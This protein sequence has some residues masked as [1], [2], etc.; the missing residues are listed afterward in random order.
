MAK[1]IMISGQEIFELARKLA[2]NPEVVKA[3]EEQL[4]ED[5]PGPDDLISSTAPPAPSPSSTNRKQ[6]TGSGEP[7]TRSANGTPT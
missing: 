2:A 4:A 3:I 7:S 5:P 1:L 6:K